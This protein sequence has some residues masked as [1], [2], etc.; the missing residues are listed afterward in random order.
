VKVSYDGAQTWTEMGLN[1]PGFTALAIAW[2]DNGANGL[3]VGMDY[4][5]YYID[6]T[7]D[8]WQPYSNNLPN[9]IVNELEV[10]TVDG[11]LYAGT[12][13]R[14]LWATPLA[15]PVLGVNDNTIANKV[16]LVPNPANDE[17]SILI[18]EA[19][20]ADIRVFDL[21]GKLVI[22]QLDVP[23]VTR[24]TLDVSGLNAGVYFVRINSEIGTVTKKLIKR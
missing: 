20:E 9:V 7:L 16:S 2:H 5:V 22:F 23:V 21:T 15:E 1:L 24:Y 4:G 11:K 18:T 19:V 13:G 17:V 8:E 6:S 10:N 12:Y 14:G 3:Y